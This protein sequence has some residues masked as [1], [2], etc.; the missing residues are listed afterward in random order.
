[1]PWDRGRLQEEQCFSQTCFY[2]MAYIEGSGTPGSS[3]VLVWMFTG[4]R[5]CSCRCVLC[6]SLF[7][8]LFIFGSFC[9]W[10]ITSGN[11]HDSLAL[12]ELFK[13][14]CPTRKTF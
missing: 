6:A 7:L 10:S 3:L 9:L 2:S 14:P 5:V 1:M 11:C 4:I 13:W 12:F 8:S